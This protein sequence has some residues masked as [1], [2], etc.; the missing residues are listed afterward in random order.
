MNHVN[1]SCDWLE[2]DIYSNF[3][4]VTLTLHLSNSHL[5]R[6]PYHLDRWKG[7][8]SI[9]I[10]L[11]EKD[12]TTTI[13]TISTITR[14]NIRFTFYVIRM[15]EDGNK[16]CTFKSVNNTVVYYQNCYVINEL[17]NLAIETIQTSHFIVVDG[18]GLLSGIYFDKL[19]FIE[20]NIFFKL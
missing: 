1:S 3:T 20:G 14:K 5:N 10:Q 6:L 15:K 8:V 4:G 18:D 16:H 11:H 9:A 12:L 13:K 19:L 2:I 17:R 7:P